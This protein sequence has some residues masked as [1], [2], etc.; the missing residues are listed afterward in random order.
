MRSR[1][2]RTV[3]RCRSGSGAVAKGGE[4]P[5]RAGPSSVRG[6]CRPFHRGVARQHAP[7][8]AACPTEPRGEHGV[9]FGIPLAPSLGTWPGSLLATITHHRKETHAPLGTRILHRRHHRR[10]LRLRRHRLRRGR[11]HGA[12]QAVGDVAAMVAHEDL[13]LHPFRPSAQAGDGHRLAGGRDDGRDGVRRLHDAADLV[14]RLDPAA[15]ARVGLR[16]AA[17]TAAAPTVVSR[18]SDSKE[19]ESSAAPSPAWGATAL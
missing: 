5:R 1:A 12:Q 13:G 17:C 7:R 8:G 2:A 10:R 6:R 4:P 16:R 11:D 14:R 18:E 15:E 9:R 19:E 3:K